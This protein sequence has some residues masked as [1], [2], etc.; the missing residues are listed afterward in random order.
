MSQDENQAVEPLE[1]SSRPDPYFKLFT[2]LEATRLGIQ[3]KE[4][5]LQYSPRVDLVLKVQPDI[6]LEDTM[7]DFFRTINVVEFKG[8][9]DPLTVLEFRKITVRAELVFLREEEDPENGLTVIV[10]SRSPDGFLAQARRRRIP[11]WQEEGKPWLW[12]AEVGFLDVAII[13]C[14][15]LP[16]EQKYYNWLAFAP[17]DTIKWQEFVGV[18]YDQGEWELLYSIKNMRPK[19]LEMTFTTSG[20]DINQ[21]AR[22]MGIELPDIDPEEDRKWQLKMEYLKV[23]REMFHLLDPEGQTALLSLDER[24]RLLAPQLKGSPLEQLI[25][26]LQAEFQRIAELTP[27]QLVAA[28]TPEERL[29]LLQRVAARRKKDAE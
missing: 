19:E 27:E 2:Q 16:I 21:I 12:R 10:S 1:R 6:S 5:E 3:A 15:N 8:E 24:A 14:R 28:L 18:L 17:T 26:D 7:F 22:E 25:K 4:T 9:N 20:K 23:M 13:V 29:E 11:L